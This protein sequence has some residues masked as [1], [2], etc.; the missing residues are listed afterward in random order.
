MDTGIITSGSTEDYTP[1]STYGDLLYTI[2]SGSDADGSAGGR[3][4]LGHVD[5]GTASVS[6]TYTV[7]TTTSGEGYIYYEFTRMR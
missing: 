1:D 4:Y 5:T 2:L 3:T 7:D 6:L